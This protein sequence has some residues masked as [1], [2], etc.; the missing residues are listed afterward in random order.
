MDWDAEGMAELLRKT[1]VGDTIQMR[2]ERTRLNAEV[3]DR[4]SPI[5]G[6]L[7]DPDGRARLERFTKDALGM[8]DLESVTG[9]RDSEVVEIV[10]RRAASDI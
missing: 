8:W 3:R 10:I 2:I 9:A 4:V 6:P 1:E 5:V 7:A